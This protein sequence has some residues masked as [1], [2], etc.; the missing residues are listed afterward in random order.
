MSVIP[1]Y[2]DDSS[3]QL[4]STD[5]PEGLP[6]I[7]PCLES[8][9]RE[10]CQLTRREAHFDTSAYDPYRRWCDALGPQEGLA[11]EGKVERVGWW[12]SFGRASARGRGGAQRRSVPWVIRVDSSATMGVPSWSACWTSGAM[13]IGRWEMG[14]L[15]HELTVEVAVRLRL[16]AWSGDLSMQERRRR[17]R[18]GRVVQV[19]VQ[20]AS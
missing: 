16:L 5:L 18:R 19:E 4:P 6:S 14:A 17:C 3:P 8:S 2:L 1:T 13:S 10:A 15:R 12:E 9:L 20:G 11:G 7:R